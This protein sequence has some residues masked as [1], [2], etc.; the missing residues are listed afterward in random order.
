LFE[1]FTDTARRAVVHARE[2]AR[3]LDHEHIGTEHLL[4]GLLH[5]DTE[6]AGQALRNVG[7]DLGSARI[8]VE[9]LAGRGTQVVAGEIPF[10]PR[11]KKVLELSLREALQLGHDYIGGEH[12]LL[13]LLREGE[14]VGMRAL[15]RCSADASELRR[16]ALVLLRTQGPAQRRAAGGG[17]AAVESRLAA[18]EARLERIERLLGRGEQ[19]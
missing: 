12:I 7:V 5:D 8:Q 11:A 4:L 1:R 18:I 6:G 13:G 14:G 10:T 16:Q 19:P 17:L 2:E 9:E 3:R 15:R